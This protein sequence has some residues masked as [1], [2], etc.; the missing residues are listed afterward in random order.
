MAREVSSTT[1]HSL[2]Q[3][4]NVSAWVRVFQIDIQYIS[5][6][7]KVVGSPNT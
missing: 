3:E 1:S 7:V 6:S 4:D 2:E 5:P